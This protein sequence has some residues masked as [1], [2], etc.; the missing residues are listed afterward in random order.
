MPFKS[1]GHIGAPAGNAIIWRY[2]G[3]DKFLDLITHSRLFF[4]NV[5]RLTDK[6]EAS[7]PAD[8]ARKYSELAEKKRTTSLTDKEQELFDKLHRAIRASTLVNCWSLVKTETYA[9]WKVYLGG[10]QAGVAIRSNLYNLRRALEQ[11]GDLDKLDFYIGKVQYTDALDED[12]ISE[13]S[14]VTMKREFYEYEQELRVFILESQEPGSGK[15]SAA[16]TPAASETPQTPFV[17]PASVMPPVTSPILGRYVNVK[18]PTLVGK[19]YLS[20]FMGKWFKQAVEEILRKIQPELVDRIEMS[21]I[22]DE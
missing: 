19:L 20:P 11:G 10:A 3:L 9:L 7:L 18:I 13:F 15:P 17:L 12:F 14:L 22:L 4:T 6:Y 5:H 21:S 1:H 16:E 8:L 2:M